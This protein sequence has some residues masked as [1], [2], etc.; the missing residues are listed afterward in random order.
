MNE[1]LYE[2]GFGVGQ[3]N[4]IIDGLLRVME[5]RVADA[6]Y[7]I[8]FNWNAATT[9]KRGAYVECYEVV[10]RLSEG[11]VHHSGNESYPIK[12]RSGMLDLLWEGEQLDLRQD[13]MRYMLKQL[14]DYRGTI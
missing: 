5:G 1:Y 13:L 12:Q 4:A 8:C 11:W 14:V 10:N 7:G 6:N 3:T 2:E 9:Q